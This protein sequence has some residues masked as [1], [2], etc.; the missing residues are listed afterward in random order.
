MELDRFYDTFMLLKDY[1]TGMEGTAVQCMTTCKLLYIVYNQ[2]LQYLEV[3]YINFSMC[4]IYMHVHTHTH[5]CTC[6]STCMYMCMC[7]HVHVYSWE[8]EAVPRIP[9]YLLCVY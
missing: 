7:I 1:Y 2:I 8:I 5:M 9:L 4:I 3:V 6:T